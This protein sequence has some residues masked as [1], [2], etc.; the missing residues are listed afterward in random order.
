MLASARGAFVWRVEWC[1][2]YWDVGITCMVN[3]FSILAGLVCWVSAA[4]L[5]G[6]A[7]GL[8]VLGSVLVA[9]P[10]FVTAFGQKT[11]TET[12]TK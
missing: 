3:Q 2:W 7:P 11:P 6:T 9:G 5:W 10:V 8:V 12:E 1:S 4:F